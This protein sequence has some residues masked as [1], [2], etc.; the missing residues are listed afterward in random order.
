MKTATT[1][2]LSKKT[3]DLLKN[4]SAVNVSLYMEAGNTLWTM[5]ES[6]TLCVSAKI[7]E[8][9]DTTF[10]IF[11][12]PKFLGAISLFNNPEFE[13]E[14]KYVTISGHDNS[15]VKYYYCEP[16]LIE[17]IVKNYNKIPK[18]K[19]V[20]FEFDITS[21]QIADLHRMA[22]ILELNNLAFEAKD[23][24][25]NIKV[26][27]KSNASA[28]VFNIHKSDAT[29]NEENGKQILTLSQYLKDIYP[30]DYSVSVSDTMTC[31]KNKNVEI[32]YIIANDCTIKD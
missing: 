26:F 23:E 32:Q 16:R 21:K 22:N 5:S 20:K 7:D 18:M 10:G 6:G 27:D 31:W 8:T 25:V 3:L 15:T 2:K 13:F 28:N 12:L 14:D 1:I 4:F 29:I 24:G 30:G 9:I 19:N 17:K 11:N